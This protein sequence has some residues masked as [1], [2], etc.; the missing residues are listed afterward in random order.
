MKPILPLLLV[1]GFEA[2]AGQILLPNAAYVSN[3]SLISFADPDEAYI[4][5]AADAMLTVSFSTPVRASTVGD[6][7]STWGAPPQTESAMPRVLWSGLDA[8]FN[9]I[10]SLTLSLSRTV[11]LFGFEAEPGPTD[12]HT[13]LAQYFLGN[14]LQASISRDVNGSGGALLF[15]D[16]GG[17]FDS[18]V[19]TSDADFAVGQLRYSLATP[20]PEPSTWALSASGLLLLGWRKR[21]RS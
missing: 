2:Y 19:V 6:D 12:T 21:R 20:T 3:T 4:N 7:W 18:I 5:S 9:P 14:Q 1:M 15:A 11:S 10:T 8:N 16:S 17:V 13:I